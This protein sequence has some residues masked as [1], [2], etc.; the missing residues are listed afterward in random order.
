MS[1]I[2][3]CPSCGS[4]FQEKSARGNRAINCPRCGFPIPPVS[5]A[6]GARKPAV[7]KT[8]SLPEFTDQPNPFAAV[9]SEPRQKPA[10]KPA[11]IPFV[12]AGSP[13]A[14]PVPASQPAPV[15]F[16]PAAAGPPPSFQQK[17]V[18]QAS[19]SKPKNL[20]PI[21]ALGSKPPEAKPQPAPQ[22]RSPRPI[23]T[24]QIPEPDSAKT[25]ILRP[26]QK[27]P[28]ISIEGKRPA[29]KLSNP[30]KLREAA[31]PEP[32]AA[33]TGSAKASGPGPATPGGRD[34]LEKTMKAELGIF[35]DKMDILPKKPAK[36]KAVA[37]QPSQE[38][39]FKEPDNLNDILRELIKVD[40]VIKASAL[41]KR[42]GT[43]IA[44]A[45]SSTLSDSLISIIATTVVNI[46]K[47]IIFATESG[48]LKYITLGGT[49][50]IIHLVP[51]LADIFL[52]ILTGANSKQ[53]I[54]N[55]VAK[56]VEKGVKKYLNL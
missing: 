34:S 16:R 38:L 49:N 44:S 12:P 54:V 14:R 8:A 43:I 31:A 15:Q 11:N 42:D 47:D 27:A 22:Q 10:A 45:I 25:A 50:G 53:G 7:Q 40:P 19:A 4:Q 17:P 35:K 36:K 56:N 13:A 32:R 51:I 26:Q 48:E 28:S 20:T 29:G 2:I 52:V 33:K 6:S 5:Q 23:P 55:V 46:A 37:A 18:P 41:V 24:I 30:M 1:T 21:S 3:I 39:S 9:P